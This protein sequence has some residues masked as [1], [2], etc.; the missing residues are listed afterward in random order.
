[1]RDV[2]ALGVVSGQLLSNSTAS[3]DRL[4]KSNSLVAGY[5]PVQS[6]TKSQTKSQR[7]S[8][9]PADQ[10]P[11]TMESNRGYYQG[12]RPAP[13]PLP[14]SVLGSPSTSLVVPG[15]RLWDCAV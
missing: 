15:A 13:P 10:I 3:K 7:D 9:V 1:M 4:R 12:P 2:L 8:A 14:V 11:S 5:A 6:R